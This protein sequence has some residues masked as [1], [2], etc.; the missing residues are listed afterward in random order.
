MAT[1]GSFVTGGGFP[2][3]NSPPQTIQ[4][5]VEWKR[6][7]DIIEGPTWRY[8]LNF[9]QLDDPYVCA[10]YQNP[11][12]ILGQNN[13]IEKLGEALR[14]ESNLPKYHDVNHPD[15]DSTVTPPSQL[16]LGAASGFSAFLV[17]E[18]S[19]AKS[20]RIAQQMGPDAEM[21]IKFAGDPSDKSFETVIT[22][23]SSGAVL[24]DISGDAEGGHLRNGSRDKFLAQRIYFSKHNS[25]PIANCG[26]RHQRTTASMVFA[27]SLSQGFLL[28]GDRALRSSAA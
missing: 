24:T 12:D 16:T 21:D 26:A 9:N 17:E 7:D 2:A 22:D 28:A 5:S 6:T 10:L 15:Y 19:I 13:L 8:V 23:S 20:C 25:V 11:P 27:V 1:N 14:T 4:F 18:G 3:P